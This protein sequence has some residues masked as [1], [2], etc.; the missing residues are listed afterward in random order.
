[1][2][3]DTQTISIDAGP[4]R[5]I[6][7]LE[8]VEHLPRW[9]VVFTKAVRRSGEIAE[10]MAL[11]I[12]TLGDRQ[13]LTRSFRPLLPA[14]AEREPYADDDEEHARCAMEPG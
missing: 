4:D 6:T 11:R 10:Q 2:R 13:S 9:A 8:D 14:V 12:A 5:V 3:A 1:M 7:N